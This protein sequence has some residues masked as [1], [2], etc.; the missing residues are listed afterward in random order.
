MQVSYKRRPNLQ[1]IPA[2]WL[3]GDGLIATNPPCAQPNDFWTF[4]YC[5]DNK[6]PQSLAIGQERCQR[7]CDARPKCVEFVI[8]H[9][10]R[11]TS[12]ECYLVGAH[13]DEDREFRYHDHWD[14]YER[15]ETCPN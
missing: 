4:P 1:K 15:E 10:T 6:F 7:A 14:W 2:S 12:A 13:A 11:G 8:V 3:A 9:P 5:H